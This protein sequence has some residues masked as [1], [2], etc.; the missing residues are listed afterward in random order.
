MNYSAIEET[1]T[2]KQVELRYS[3]T[4]FI[5][6]A[7]AQASHVIANSGPFRAAYD[8]NVLD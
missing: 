6:E 1:R 2:I 8:A 5:G 3:P 7:I 4:A